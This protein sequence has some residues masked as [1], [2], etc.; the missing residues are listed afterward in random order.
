MKTENNHVY[1]EN[2]ATHKDK[3][4]TVTLARTCRFQ[5]D[6]RSVLQIHPPCNLSLSAKLSAGFAYTRDATF[7]V[8][9]MPSFDRE[10]FS[11]SVDA[12]FVLA[13]PFHH[14]DLEPECVGVSSRG[15]GSSVKREAIIIITPPGHIRYT[16]EQKSWNTQPKQSG[17]KRLMRVFCI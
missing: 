7:S 10:M 13:L 2:H 6:Y 17:M 1:L 15:V 3:T 11:G 12:G 9:I 14:A 8:A 4:R 16:K 5:W